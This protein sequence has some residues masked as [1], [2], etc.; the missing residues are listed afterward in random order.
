MK[1]RF[2]GIALQGASMKVGERAIVEALPL[3]P[4]LAEYA[5]LS[6]YEVKIYLCLLG[7]GSSGAK[8]ISALTGVPRTKIYSAL[9]R[10]MEMGLIREAPGTP[11]LY[12]P[13]PP[14]EAFGAVLGVARRRVEDFSSLV[15]MLWG[16]YEA[17]SEASQ[18]SRGEFWHIFDEAEISARCRDL[19]R[20]SN[21]RVLIFAGDFA[22]ALLFNEANRELDGLYERGVE[23]RVFSPL[24][25]E[26]SPLARELSYL[27][28]VR[29]TPLDA[30]LLA[31]L[32]DG[33]RGLLARVE[34]SGHRGRFVEAIYAEDQALIHL[35]SL[36]LGG[37]E[38]EAQLLEPLEG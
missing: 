19:L 20:R 14:G 25:P 31:L 9:R 4:K 18:S 38:A 21:H 6:E 32:S 17:S 22:L 12:L 13:T 11:S 35:L 34:V 28:E 2:R 30:P 33:E 26:M 16:I 10:M 37:V 15:T 23:V 3:W 36:I 1:G 24:H 27:F 5:G 7:L 29:R 8:R